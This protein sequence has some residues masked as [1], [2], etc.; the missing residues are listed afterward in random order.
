MSEIQKYFTTLIELKATVVLLHH[1]NPNPI[2]KTL[3]S[4]FEHIRE[5]NLRKISTD[6]DFSSTISY[7]F[8]NHDQ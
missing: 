2:V 5:F 4:D 6:V 7:N 1:I 8:A 3:S